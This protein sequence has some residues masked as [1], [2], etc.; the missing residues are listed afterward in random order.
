MLMIYK[1]TEQSGH[2][3]HT[4]PDSHHGILLSA[5]INAEKQ[6][7]IQ[8]MCYLHPQAMYVATPELYSVL[9][10]NLEE[11]DV[12]RLL[13]A[14]GLLLRNLSIHSLSCCKDSLRN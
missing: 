11:S 7:Y 13:R 4:F 2:C 14:A 3:T 6:L 8:S 9:K 10:L 1:I 5:F 12:S